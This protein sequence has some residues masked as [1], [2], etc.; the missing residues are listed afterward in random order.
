[1]SKHDPCL[2]LCDANGNIT[3]YIDDSGTVAAHYEYDSFGF[4]TAESGTKASD[5]RF[6]FSSKYLGLDSGLYYY[7]FRYYRP[8]IGRWLSRDPIGERSE[9]NRYGFVGNNGMRFV[10]VLGMYPY[11]DPDVRGYD[12][13]YEVG[14]TAD[15]YYDAYV[16]GSGPLATGEG[17][18]LVITSKN[19]NKSGHGRVVFTEFGVVSG[20]GG[21]FGDCILRFD[22]GY[23]QKY[24]FMG[25]GVGFGIKSPLG[26]VGGSGQ[27]GDAYGVHSPADFSGF[28]ISVSL[29]GGVAGS[30]ASG[31]GEDPAASSTVGLGTIGSTGM[32]DVYF[33]VGEPYPCCEDMT[34][35]P[36]ED[37]ECCK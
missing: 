1:M 29:S 10:D 30:I 18:P 28:F 13:P 16:N 9:N 21:H 17:P 25:L 23:C 20:A 35:A 19:W 36:N 12:D 4:D 7:G 32:G 22:N 34:P 5:F 14:N 8:K 26:P 15:M 3:E 6:R 24:F 33:L 31:I 2:G 11:G 27:G 37:L